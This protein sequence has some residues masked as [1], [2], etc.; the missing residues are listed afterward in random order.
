MNKKGFTLIELLATIII[1]AIIMTLVLPSALKVR[2]KNQNKIYNEYEQMMVEYAKISPLNN[3]DLI[4]LIDLEELDK[5]KQECSGYVEIDHSTLIPTYTPYITCGDQ[6]TT[7][8]YNISYAKTIV[9]IPTCNT[10]LVYNGKTQSLINPNV[11]YIVTN[12]T[13]KDIGKQNV[14]V[15]LIDT[16]EYIWVDSTTN[17]KTISDCE[18]HKREI[19]LIADT[20]MMNYG[21]AIPSNSYTITNGITGE[22]PLVGNVSYTYKNVNND[23]VSITSSTSVGAYN[24]V[25]SATVDSNYSLRIENGALIIMREV[26]SMTVTSPQSWSTTFANN[27]QEKTFTAASGAQGAVTYSILS[28]QKD[29]SPVEYF[30]IPNNTINKI[31]M[32][33]GTPAGNYSVVI[34]AIAAGDANHLKNTMTITL[35]VTVNALQC[36]APSNIQIGTDGKVSWTASSNCSSAAYQVKVANGAYSN[37]TNPVNKL[38]DIIASTGSRTICVKVVAPSSN[39]SSNEACVSKNVYSVTLTK[40]TGISSV[41]G[42]G[43]YITGATVTLGATPSA[44][45]NWSK[46]TQTSG[47]TQVSTTNAYQTTITSNL[48]YTANSAAASYTLT[49]LDNIFAAQSQVTGGVTATYTENGSYLTLNGT[50]SN[51]DLNLWNLDRRTI[52]SGDVY[53]VTV[54]HVSGSLTCV[55][56]SDCTGSKG[57]PLFVFELTIDGSRFSDRATSPASYVDTNLPTSGTNNRTLTVGSSKATANGL[58]FWIYQQNANNAVFNNYKVQILISKVHTK[59]VTYNSNYGSLDTPYKQG[60]DFNGWYTD[61]ASGTEVTSTTKFTGTSN[62]TIYAKY[63]SHKLNLQ[64]NGNGND[65]TWCSTSTTYSMDSSKFA[66]IT[67]SS[68][69]NTQ[70]VAFGQFISYGSGLNNYNNESY[71]CFS[72]TGYSAVPSN[73]WVLNSDTSKKYGQDVKTYTAIGIAND[74]GCNLATTSTCTARVNVNWKSANPIAVTSSQSWSPTYSTSA[75]DKAFTAAT[76]AQGSVTYSIQSQ[77]KGSTAV[78]SFSIPT[79]STATLRMAASTGAGTYTVVIRATAAGNNNYISGYKDITMTVTVGRVNI[80]FPSCSS[81]YYNGSSQTLFAAHT[82]GTYT[83]SAITGTNAGTY[84]GNLTPTANYQWSSGSN[85]TSARE[86]S[87]VINASKAVNTVNGVTTGYSTLDAALKASTTGTTKLISNCT[88]NVDLP[89]GY[90]K[91]LDLNGKTL[92]TISNHGTLTLKNG[93]VEMGGGWAVANY[94]TMTVTDV[95]VNYTSTDTGCAVVNSKVGSTTPTMTI[96]N[97]TITSNSASLD[98]DGGTLNAT[99]V[100]ITKDGDGVEVWNKHGGRLTFTG[101]SVPGGAICAHDN[102]AEYDHPT[103][104][105]ANDLLIIINPTLGSGVKAFGKIIHI[106]TVTSGGK[107]YVMTGLLNY[108]SSSDKFQC[109]SWTTANGQDD[110]LWHGEDTSVSPGLQ[111]QQSKKYCYFAR[112]THN[113]ETGTYSTHF[114]VNDKV[115]TG[116][117]WTWN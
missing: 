76:G 36:S 47:G 4:D 69:R 61:A 29:S 53:S 109:P 35:N 32:A 81:V 48:S 6:Y 44:G 54:K 111:V 79:S 1:I 28:Q 23:T 104:A 62:Q 26:N 27:S 107:P 91:T 11:N 82:S 34:N 42:A 24:I 93:K 7:Q 65:V 33:S 43:N 60:F 77:K 66:I 85:V 25:P 102:C 22:N 8:N 56:K 110:L 14:S 92:S 106:K 94:A 86:L 21:G 52:N 51:T 38:N 99:N 37:S 64:Y 70:T 112:S 46:W 100:T 67:S 105:N 30:S 58:Q 72:K 83:N 16:N 10:N 101:G 9:P 45:Y 75:Q 39:Y 78:S 98:N 2:R 3:Q 97:V 116:T 49:Y 13:R 12:G 41:T 84:K 87:C 113:N 71:F 114:Y 20:K 5:V 59:S 17:S 19:T 40:G 73:E 18:I 55:D 117:N 57:R 68:S 108:T 80:S 89:S 15:S 95:T 103:L 90:T 115:V 96:S 63:T 50:L 31:Q 74:A 88:E